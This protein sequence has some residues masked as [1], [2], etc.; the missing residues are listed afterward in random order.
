VGCLVGTNVGRYDG[1]NEGMLFP[2]AK[3]MNLR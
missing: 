2:P 1:A 3:P